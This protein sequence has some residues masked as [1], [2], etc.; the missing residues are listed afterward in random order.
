MM[1]DRPLARGPCGVLPRS[2]WLRSPVMII[3]LSIPMRV[4]NIFICSGVLFCISS[5][6]MKALSK[7]RPRMNPSG[8]IS[9]FPLEIMASMVDLSV[10]IF[11]KLSTIGC[12][13]GAIF[14]S[15]LPGKYPRSSEVDTVGLVIMILLMRGSLSSALA[16]ATH[17]NRVFP[18]PAGH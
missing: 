15:T 10:Y 17:A 1:S 12:T 13:H 2:L 5:A 18:Q 9:I 7:V 3:L 6:M 8:D 11:R 16:A 14:E 4:R